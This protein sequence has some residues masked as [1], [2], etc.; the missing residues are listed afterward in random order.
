[1]RFPCF[2]LYS[3]YIAQ[4]IDHPQQQQKGVYRSVVSTQRK[5]AVLSCFRQASLHSLPRFVYF[6]LC[7]SSMHGL[8][9]LVCFHIYTLGVNQKD[10][11][12]LTVCLRVCFRC[13]NRLP[14]LNRIEMVGN[15]YWALREKELLWLV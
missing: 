4:Q 11:I 2:T 15:A 3:F 7:Y 12:S 14:N 8:L 5:R 9:F 6:L 1:M 13:T 10:R